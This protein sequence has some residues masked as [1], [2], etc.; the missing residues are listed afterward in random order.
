MTRA[1]DTKLA[2]ID[3]FINTS[4]SNLAR[5]KAQK[6]NLEQS[7]ADTER[8][9]GTVTRQHLERIR[10]VENR[11][12]QYEAEIQQKLDEAERLRQQFARDLQRVRE[13]RML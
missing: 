4:R 11:I 9:G 5:V 10:S 12:R 2:S 7:A 3:G 6:R 8:A 13:L 1:R